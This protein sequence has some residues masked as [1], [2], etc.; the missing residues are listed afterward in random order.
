[1]RSKL[2][3]TAFNCI[4]CSGVFTHPSRSSHQEQCCARCDRLTS[5][6]VSERQAQ[7]LKDF[8][9]RQC[10]KSYA[11]VGAMKMHTRTHTL[12]CRCQVCGKAFSRPWLLQG[13]VRTHTGE[14]PF[15]CGQCGRA[16]ADRSNLR[17][18][19]QTHAQ[20]KKYRCNLCSKTFSRM[21]LL[22]K[23]K[24]GSCPA[25]ETLVS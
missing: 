24:N 5:T 23:H 10:S 21:S 25:S 13:H 11:S 3:P 22:L 12:P 16:F 6:M 4:A 20:V 8:A 18:H 14:K 15:E 17:A 19:L 2:E 9:C 7:T 1:M